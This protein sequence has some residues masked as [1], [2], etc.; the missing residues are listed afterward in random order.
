MVILIYNCMCYFN[1]FAQQSAGHHRTEYLVELK[2]EYLNSQLFELTRPSPKWCENFANAVKKFV[3][4][5][6]AKIQGKICKIAAKLG[7]NIRQNC[8]KMMLKQRENVNLL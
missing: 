7:K 8:V 3:F 2:V 4:Q 5:S 6:K 1:G